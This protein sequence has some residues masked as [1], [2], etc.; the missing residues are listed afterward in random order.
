MATN[1]KCAAHSNPVLISAT[2][3]MGCCTSSDPHPLLDL[4][5]RRPPVFQLALSRSTAAAMQHCP[6]SYG[7]RKVNNNAADEKSDAVIPEGPLRLLRILNPS[8]E[9]RVSRGSE[10][11]GCRCHLN[12]LPEA[13]EVVALESAYLQIHEAAARL[14]ISGGIAGEVTPLSAAAG[15]RSPVVHRGLRGSAHDRSHAE[16]PPVAAVGRCAGQ[17]KVCVDAEGDAA[18]VDVRQRWHARQDVRVGALSC[19]RPVSSSV[20]PPVVNTCSG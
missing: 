10:A 11:M 19:I 6:S 9:E 16:Q 1:I 5:Q 2:C 8:D 14:L 20:A 7:K 18:C 4:S 15:T 12:S 3:L 17:V 13:V